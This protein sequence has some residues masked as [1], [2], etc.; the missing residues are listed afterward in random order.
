MRKQ[1]SENEVVEEVALK[2][3]EENGG[4]ERRQ[5]VKWLGGQISGA[6]LGEDSG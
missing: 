3:V 4:G 2:Q 6:R 1:L 5:V